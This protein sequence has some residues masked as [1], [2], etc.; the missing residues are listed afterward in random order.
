M[1]TITRRNLLAT[2]AAGTVALVA[3]STVVFA[4]CGHDHRK[5]GYRLGAMMVDPTTSSAEKARVLAS[6]R[7]PGCGATIEPDGLSYGQHMPH[8]AQ[9]QV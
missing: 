5:M 7:C 4:G 2:T 1:N 6:A 3:G 9:L 8:G